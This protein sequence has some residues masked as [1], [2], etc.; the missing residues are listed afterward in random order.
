MAR[1]WIVGLVC[2]AFGV[3]TASQ[4][5]PQ[6]LTLATSYELEQQRPISDFELTDQYGKAFTKQRLLDKWSLIYIGY[7]SCPDIC[8]TATAKLSQATQTLQQHAPFQ[9]IFISVDPQRDTTTRL[10]DYMTFFASGFVAV[11]ASHKQLLPLTRELGFV[12]AMIGEGAAYQVDHSAS[13][14]LISP[15]GK[16]VAVIKPRADEPGRL[17]Q[18]R[19]QE[20]IADIQKIIDKYS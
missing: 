3:V 6:P 12:Y 5:T 17:P 13:Y 4:M 15:A 9:T 10:H 8:P 16:R 18:I 2:V 19:N 14:I 7:T 11:T 1:Y 20:L